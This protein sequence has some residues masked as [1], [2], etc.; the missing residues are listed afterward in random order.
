MSQTI[1]AVETSCD[2]TAAAVIKVGEPSNGLPEIEVLS[3][4]IASQ[5]PLHQLTGGVV[6][7]V[8]AR[9]QLEAILPIIDEAL[10]NAFSQGEW[11]YGLGRPYLDE[12]D[13]LAVTEGPGLIGSLLVGVE[14]V[15]VIGLALKKPVIPINHYEGHLLSFL[16][17]QT[18]I[19]W[20]VLVLTAS[21]GHTSLYIMDSP[22]EVTLLGKT[23]DD[24]AGEAFDKAAAQ[25]GLPYPGGPS[26]SK[27]A[28]QGNQNRF[29]LPRPMLGNTHKRTP[30]EFKRDPSA[31]P[32]D[33]G[34]KYDFSFSGLKTALRRE[35][36]KTGTLKEQDVADLA[37]SFQA[38]VVESL[39]G[40]MKR[41]ISGR[42]VGGLAVVGGVA[43]NTSL[44]IH[45][46]ALAK[47]QNIPLYL[48]AKGL[49]TDNAAMIGCAAAIKMSQGL[50]KNKW[51]IPG[52]RL[53]LL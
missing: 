40:Q 23:R 16:P 8:A 6:P 53:P 10:F 47:A 12:I 25:L 37:A 41:A 29:I 2:E 44:Q 26:I 46:G 30:S 11:Q 33:D 49:S 7:E 43:A 48:P 20:P 31:T 28:E 1:L 27:A 32:L 4:S 18:D 34:G 5:I 13:A 22:A 3:N 21:G 39:V 52:A 9:A 38:A 14:A 36:E 42:S 24:A 51:A 50:P 17:G 35:V 19:K 45:A 15:N